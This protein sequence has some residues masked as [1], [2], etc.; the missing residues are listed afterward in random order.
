MN[1]DTQLPRHTIA[2]ALD[3]RASLTPDRVALWL[4]G[5]PQTFGHFQQRVRAVSAALRRRH[6][7]KGDRFAIYLANCSEFPQA[8]VGGLY[9]GIQ[10]VTINTAYTGEFLRHQLA[11]SGSRL[12]VTS[13]DL[14][15][16][17]VDVLPGCPGVEALVVVGDEFTPSDLAA[18][19]PVLTW[20]DFCQGDIPEDHAPVTLDDP[21]AIFYTSGTT[22]LSKGVLLSQ[23]HVAGV[24]QSNCEQVGLT[25]GDVTLIPVP[26][27][28]V[29]GMNGVLHALWA[30][31]STIIERR[32]K[33]DVVLKRLSD[34]QVTVLTVVGPI[35][36]ML[37]N[38]PPGEF[39][40]HI[41]LRAMFGTPIP[42]PFDDLH[43]RYGLEYVATAYGQSEVQPC[44]TGRL[45]EIP[46]GSAGRLHSNLDAR[47]VDDDGRDVPPGT[48]GE[49]ILKPRVPHALF[50]GYV[51]NP[52]ATRAAFIDGWYHTG[53][54]LR[55][56]QDGIYFWMD[57]KKDMVRR[58]GENISSAEV[59]TAINT[60]PDIVEVAIHGVPS[61]LGED[62]VK[63]VVVLADGSALTHR[64]LHDF[65]L[66]RMPRFAVPRYIEFVDALPRN[67]IGRIQKFQLRS[68]GITDRTWDR[69][70]DT[71]P[72][73]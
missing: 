24:A 31:C 67:P 4:D 68:A 52:E 17:V 40:K 14:A 62:E 64:Q 73:G 47:L 45:P 69:H 63:A 27:F 3:E 18:K 58:R 26:L 66:G 16:A 46:Y 43:R 50:D 35:L 25:A 10:P 44:I 55:R 51:N 72:V 13:A 29:S 57:R 5:I 41:K 38:Q 20:A 23:G 19:V 22:G 6:L 37:W 34:H 33:A 54:I 32:F 71:G 12:V 36:Q 48:P 53:D 42:V 8:W 15:P 1:S 59:E 28:H 49:L 61:E 70:A 21:G 65:C 39:D 60:H 7:A 2:A 11:D 56:D 9:L 30:G